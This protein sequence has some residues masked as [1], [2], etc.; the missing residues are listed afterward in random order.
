MAIIPPPD[1]EV[2]PVPDKYTRKADDFTGA[3]AGGRVLQINLGF[4]RYGTN[5]A[6]HAAAIVLSLIL[7]ACI[8]GVLI[9]NM[10]TPGGEKAFQWLGSAF[11]FVA[12]VAVGKGG[13]SNNGQ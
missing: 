5:D 8:I 1:P 3:N 11:L 12:G 2:S 4:L 6:T 10:N 7:L 9:F 13:S